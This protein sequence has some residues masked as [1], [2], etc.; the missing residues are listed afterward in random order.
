MVWMLLIIVH[1]K[2][3]GRPVA[4]QTKES[5][6]DDAQDSR[7]RYV[8]SWSNLASICYHHQ[9]GVGDDPANWTFPQFL[10]CLSIAT[11]P[12]RRQVL[13]APCLRLT[14]RLDLGTFQC[15]LQCKAKAGTKEVHYC[16]KKRDRHQNHH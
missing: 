16:R 7:Q 8:P 1:Q 4:L 10:L 3:K 11:A 6:A 15:V 13:A 2:K 14:C 5:K 12:V 9:R